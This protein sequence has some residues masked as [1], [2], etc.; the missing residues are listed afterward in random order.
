MQTLRI[1]IVAGIVALL[2]CACTETAPPPGPH[3]LT[4][5]LRWVKGYGA[6][7]EKKVETGLLW[8]LSF[9][10]AEFPRSAPKAFIWK[11][12]L[13]TVDFDRIG[14]PAAARPAWVELIAQLKG[15]DEYRHTGGMD[16]GRFLMLTLCSPRNYYVL[17]GVAPHLEQVRA[18]HTFEREQMAVTQSEIAV[19]NRLIDIGEAHRFDEIGFIAYEGTG[20]IANG[21]FQKKEIEVLE[22][23]KNGQLRFALYD[24]EGN[25]KT[26]A[27]PALTSAGKPS[28]CLWCHEIRLQPAIKNLVD[29]PGYYTTQQFGALIAER[30]KLVDQYRNGLDSKVDF[31]RTQDHTFA[32]LLYLTF[33]EPSAERLA[34]EWNV[35]VEQVMTLLKAKPTHAQ[36]EFAWLGSRLYRREDVDPL[37]PY[38]V[39]K[40]ASDPREPSSYEPEVLTSKQPAQAPGP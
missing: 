10:G 14:I 19:G 18:R 24:L 16:I 13:V 8:A 3:D 28:K 39:L 15:S 22:F 31:K 36:P 25:L 38:P 37:A 40:V 30:M 4:L 1:M 12:R 5:T 32:E 33:M 2:S 27:T 21:S 11:D 29:T 23:M 26:S 20:A 17:T 6:E 9:L 34:L 7:N 35:P